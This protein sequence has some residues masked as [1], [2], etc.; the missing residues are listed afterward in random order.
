MSED[1][2]DYLLNFDPSNQTDIDAWSA[3]QVNL[4][5]AFTEA[6]SQLQ[7]ITNYEEGV[8]FVTRGFSALL[9]IPPNQ[10]EEDEVV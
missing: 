8:E 6:K 9:P 7:A 1:E 3:F 10:P 2:I 5:L 4:K